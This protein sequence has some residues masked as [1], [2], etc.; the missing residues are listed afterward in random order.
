M[1]QITIRKTG[2]DNAF[3]VYVAD[4]AFNYFQ[5]IPTE[6][7]KSDI[8][9]QLAVKFLKNKPAS[10]DC[11]Y[12]KSLYIADTN[13][14]VTYH[15]AFAG[16]NESQKNLL[17]DE[18]AELLSDYEFTINDI[19]NAAHQS[20][21][22]KLAES[23]L[24]EICAQKNPPIPAE[25]SKA[26]SKQQNPEV[27]KRDIAAKIWLNAHKKI[28]NSEISKD[29]HELNAKLFAQYGLEDIQKIFDQKKFEFTRN[30]ADEVLAF[31][32][33]ADSVED[34]E[35]NQYI[36]NSAET[37]G[38]YFQTQLDR[39]NQVIIDPLVES[40][41][42]DMTPVKL[43]ITEYIEAK[44]ELD[45]IR[46]ALAS[47]LHNAAKDYYRTIWE[48]AKKDDNIVKNMRI[49][50]AGFNAIFNASK[51]D[52][53][54]FI[55]RQV[56]KVNDDFTLTTRE[57]TSKNFVATD[58]KT[59][60]ARLT[61][62]L[63]SSYEWGKI[64]KG[65]DAFTYL[66][67]RLNDMNKQGKAKFGVDFFKP[68]T[69]QLVANHDVVF[70]DTTTKKFHRFA[71]AEK[72]LLNIE[73][74]QIDSVV[75]QS[76]ASE[77]TA[78]Q[79]AAQA[80]ATIT[81]Q[82]AIAKNNV[83]VFASIQE[84]S[85]TISAD[86]DLCQTQFD[87]VNTNKF[88]TYPEERIGKLKLSDRAKQAFDETFFSPNTFT[89]IN[90]MRHDIN[91]KITI[92]RSELDKAVDIAKRSALPSDGLLQPLQPWLTEKIDG[93][94]S[95][96]N[97]S[98]YTLNKL[99]LDTKKDLEPAF[100]A[101]ESFERIQEARQNVADGFTLLLNS[102]NPIN[103]VPTITATIALQNTAKDALN[104]KLPACF[105]E[106]LGKIRSQ[107]ADQEKDS[108]DLL[109][110]R[111][112]L[113]SILNVEYWGHQHHGLVKRIAIEN[114]GES[115]SIPEPI[116]DLIAIAKRADFANWSSNPAVARNLLAA[117]KGYD[118]KNSRNINVRNFF[119]ILRN[120]YH[121]LESIQQHQIAHPD[122]L[123]SQHYL[124]NLASVHKKPSFMERNP[125]LSRSL[126]GAG[127][128]L[129]VAGVVIVAICLTG[130]AGG[131]L[132]GFNLLTAWT[133]GAF[134]AGGALTGAVAAV[135]TIGAGIGAICG[136]IIKKCSTPAAARAKHAEPAPRAKVA[137]E[138]GGNPFDNFVSTTQHLQS[139]QGL[140][141]TT[142][143]NPFDIPNFEPAPRPVAAAAK[144]QSPTTGKHAS[145]FKPRA[146]TSTVSA[147][148]AALKEFQNTVVTNL[149]N[150]FLNP[151]TCKLSVDTARITK[152]SL[153][154]DWE[155]RHNMASIMTYLKSKFPHSNTEERICRI[156]AATAEEFPDIEPAAL[157][158]ALPEQYANKMSKAKF[159]M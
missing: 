50:Q 130:G 77:E 65:R 28:E 157:N 116:S 72:A 145:I 3:N 150:D 149:I 21:M 42:K 114:N 26:S 60:Q 104:Q 68:I 46:N 93:G 141:A 86:I 152:S 134:A 5:P 155:E 106:E 71:K 69:R 151:D 109:K 158:R 44:K 82:L 2:Q 124:H 35:L 139:R 10:A 78:A 76:S 126:I 40:I 122:I 99:I 110:C 45:P 43:A 49:E 88:S 146:Q 79:M 38:A 136:A 119:E 89:L 103:F 121:T 148:S 52:D 143:T 115:Y 70:D 15:Y 98:I 117:M 137:E 73:P 125:V 58:I 17:A 100:T 97:E 39:V 95:E 159:E 153:H 19:E 123:T 24:Q 112:L 142:S 62:L 13:N 127:I 111:L 1:K 36:K 74:E 37:L 32:Q 101:L 31:Q 4:D 66:A 59:L 81:N 14:S 154:L 129:L 113:N 85:A 75:M 22:L 63:N 90:G 133:G 120:D 131:I 57:E 23:V 132:A 87:A 92:L 108:A 20:R 7:E 27:I 84:S 51:P 8:L 30:A 80:V 138:A 18:S 12:L 102:N 156:I 9:K 16:Q 55:D 48:D 135:A 67:T 83:T 107:I 33:T 41:K 25:D 56:A 34:V 11:V 29:A 91:K 94:I 105:D 147:D 118:K 128:A 96:T 140:A 54:K 144:Q 47:A 6:D 53:D 64:K 61:T